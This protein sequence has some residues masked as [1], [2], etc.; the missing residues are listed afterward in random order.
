MQI[1]ISSF[2]VCLFKLLRKLRGL[3][4]ESHLPTLTL[5]LAVSF[6]EIKKEKDKNPPVLSE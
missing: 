3:K 5:F 4:R 1:L 2:P 6:S